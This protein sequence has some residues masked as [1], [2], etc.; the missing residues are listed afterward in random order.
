MAGRIRA[1]DIALVRER[2]R[3]DE[4]VGAQ[5]QL[6]SAGG[7]SLKGLC[8]FHDEKSPSFHVTPAKGFWHCFGCDQGG[9]VIDF[10]MKIDH[11]PFGEAVERLASR[12]GVALRYEEGG[13]APQR[14]TGQRSRLV[15]ANAAAA[16]F[17]AE[18]LGSGEAAVG[19]LFLEERGFDRDAATRFGVGYAPG[20]WDTLTKHLRGQRFSEEELRLAGLARDARHGLI[21]RFRERLVWPIRDL[22]GDVVGFGARKLSTDSADTSPKYLNTPETAIYKKSQILYGVDLAKSAISKQQ[23]A[24]VV[25]GY[26][27]VMACHLAG[28]PTAVATCGTAFG[29]EHTRILRRL[30]MD[31]DEFRGEVI[32]TFDGDAAGQKAA[33]RAFEG[34]QRFATQTFVAV[35]PDGL[36]PCDLRRAKGDAAVRD[37]VADRVPL[38]EFAVR[39]TLERHNLET[40]EGRMAALDAVAPIVADIRDRGMR[41]RYAINVDRWLGFL[42]E[43][44]VLDRVAQVAARRNQPGHR[45]GA[46]RP[47]PDARPEDRRDDRRDERNQRPGSPGADDR[48]TESA[49]PSG[50][51]RRLDGVSREPARLPDPRDPA[52][53]AEREALKLAV[54]HPDLVGAHFDTLDTEVFSY[55][56]HEAIHAAIVAA[57][58]TGAAADRRQWVH[59]VR[60]QTS[61]EVA[62]GLVSALAVEPLLNNLEPSERYATAVMARVEEVAATRRVTQL[63]SKLQ[64]INP[65]DE[66][67]TYNRLFGQLVALE[68][69]RI[70]LREL[71]IGGL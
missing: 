25:E 6:R 31:Q 7:G 44:F 4:I 60:E 37:L 50:P 8:P 64:R 65:V 26:T 52:A 15:A 55:A 61:D 24:V 43:K 57:G 40:T 54:Q 1:D 29:E 51:G 36:D 45:G 58:G 67:E 10:V 34:D 11:L 30:L 35:Q 63:K 66:A 12:S 53:K 5:L 22:S 2:V 39:T 42:D 17:Y 27:D 69:E 9:D 70:A 32:F 14:Q 3:I 38:F 16:A 21:D 13:S 56:V 46:G 47:R 28:V 59:A 71:A 49:G 68:R 48:G 20:G 19:R 23:R 41:Q 62:R 18:Q 33:L